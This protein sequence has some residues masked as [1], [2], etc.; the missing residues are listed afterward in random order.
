MKANT[1]YG[2]STT[3]YP[4]YGVEGFENLEYQKDTTSIVNVLSASMRE[5]VSSVV[6]PTKMTS[7]GAS[8]FENCKSLKIDITLPS[9][10]TKIGDSA[11]KN[12]G[13]TFVSVDLTGCTSSPSVGANA[14]SG[15]TVKKL[16]IDNNGVKANY[17]ALDEKYPFYG[18]NAFE[19]LEYKSGTTTAR[20][21][22]SASMRSTITTASIPE[23]VTVYA[24]EV[25]AD[26]SNLKGEFS[27]PSTVISIGDSAFKNSGLTFSI[28]H[29]TG[30]SSNSSVGKNAFTGTTVKI[31][32]LN[33]NWVRTSYGVSAAEYPFYNVKGF[34]ILE[35]MYGT[36]T[37][38]DVLSDSMRS[39]ITT[40]YIPDSI[41]V[42]ASEFL[43]NTPNLKGE[44]SLPSTVINIGDSAFKNCGLTFVSVDLSSCSSNSSVGKNAFTGTT[45]KKL[46][47]NNNGVRVNSNYGVSAEEYPFYNVEGFTTLEYK[48]D[49]TTARNVL[50]DSMRK[51]LT[52][53]TVPKTVT[54][55]DDNVF[56]DCTLL[57]EISLPY[58]T[59]YE[60]NT[61]KNCKA[62][63]VR[64]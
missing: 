10:V 1:N 60:K 27:I 20:N 7:I 4:F 21:V 62:K 31:L 22:L 30:C 3:S 24:S 14:F 23:S 52:E 56:S 53:V 50:S 13:I 45:V 37:A 6:F 15:T 51:T 28:V 64:Y 57:E 58:G 34:E 19:T 2:V 40:A 54:K 17:G 39:S 48:K 41:T 63:M 26:T 49:T 42:Y 18:V 29:L 46:I 43:S 38:R 36:T 61:F 47:V 5:T 25:L 35:Y 33:N 59:V 11:F 16:I 8:A 9:T 55:I 12:S 44:L 32:I